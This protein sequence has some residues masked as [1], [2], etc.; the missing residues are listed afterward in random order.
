MSLQQTPIKILLCEC[1]SQIKHFHFTHDTKSDSA[2]CGEIIHRAAAGNSEALGVLLYDVTKPLVEQR[3]PP[4][5]QAQSD[6]LIQ[7]V[8]LRLLKKFHHPTSPF[9]AQGFPAYRHY[10]N[11]TI[12]KS[13]S[14]LR[15]PDIHIPLEGAIDQSAMAINQLTMA[16]KEIAQV[17]EDQETAGEILR[18]I[19]NPTGREIIR[20]R[21]I[22][23]ESYDDIL[24]ALQLVNPKLNKKKIYKL[25]ENS[26][27]QLKKSF[28][29]ERI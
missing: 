21:Y 29:V 6:D 25:A 23:N 1:S 18:R 14:L 9:I 12:K 28:G 16:D 27:K 3:C 5:L 26:L 4:D 7:E 10:L 2:S 13:I 19:T 20:R 22:N 24:V 11:L 15:Q 8:L 17:I